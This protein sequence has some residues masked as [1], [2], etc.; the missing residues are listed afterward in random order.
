MTTSTL[1]DAATVASDLQSEDPGRIRAAL[2][3]I[4]LA[5][6]RREYAPLP[7]PPP[8]VL[9]AFGGDVQSSLVQAY[10]MMLQHYP[11]FQHTLSPAELRA[12]MLEAVIRYG[13][14]DAQLTHSIG[15]AIRTQ[16]HPNQA[17]E[18]ALNAL[19]HTGLD[20]ASVSIVARQLVDTL[21][22]SQAARTGVIKGLCRWT[23]M[24]EFED[25]IAQVYPQLSPEETALLESAK[26]G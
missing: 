13:R 5:W 24:E 3:A 25:V 21:L 4:D 19:R 10:V 6:K 26:D 1:L 2:E 18:D 15:M 12:M 22:D 11:A 8:T 14:G 23:Q 16:L 7:L 17:A 20:E 9:E